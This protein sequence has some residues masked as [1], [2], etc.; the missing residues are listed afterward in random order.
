MRRL[1][2]KEIREKR[3]WILLTA[4]SVAG[5]TAFR[6][7]YTFLG[8]QNLDD[9]LCFPSVVVALLYG[10]TAYSS[11]IGW[12][13][14]DFLFSRPISW[15]RVLCAKL[16]V[17]FGTML[18]A[19]LVGSAILRL[20]VPESHVAILSAYRLQ[21]IG[22]ALLVMGGPYLAGLASSLIF[23]GFLGSVTVLI[24]VLGA[25]AA[26]G[27]I[28]REQLRGPVWVFGLF[29]GCWAASV[30]VAAIITARFGLTLAISRRAIRYA[31]VL[32]VGSIV[33]AALVY[34]LPRGNWI[35]GK[36]S[37]YWFSPDGSYVL[38][39]GVTYDYVGFSE[40]VSKQELW[41]TRLSD[42]LTRK[43]AWD[44]HV[45]WPQWTSDGTAYAI[46]YSGGQERPRCIFTARIDPSGRLI[47]SRFLP[48]RVGYYHLF[49]SPNGRYAALVH[50]VGTA[51]YGYG[52]EFRLV[53][54]CRQ[55]TLSGV[56]P[57]LLQY[58]WQNDNTFAWTD[59]HD[60]RHFLKIAD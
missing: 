27:A 13:T 34:A 36:A 9:Y 1:L 26:E 23:P 53:D 40:I 57:G 51:K 48:W 20:W 19:A 59:K 47:E 49:S 6:S 32:V 24:A 14:P 2:W 18:A 11:E 31:S 60:K 39:T 7:P 3:V 28:L 54:I 16:M 33:A 50:W 10:L 8:Q 5:V 46:D 25:V 37:L 56:I 44:E 42:G 58:W 17:A 45:Y 41:L 35:H 38:T 52:H 21:G 22:I 12:H 29:A 43:L 30:I 15:K 4:L 55:R